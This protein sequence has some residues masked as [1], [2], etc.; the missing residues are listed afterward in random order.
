[1]E[2]RFGRCIVGNADQKPI[3]GMAV[4][5]DAEVWSTVGSE[6]A[7]VPKENSMSKQE[8]SP[9]GVFMRVLVLVGLVAAVVLAFQMGKEI[10]TASDGMMPRNTANAAAASPGLH[11]AAAG[12]NAEAVR[13]AIAGGADP[14]AA[15]N[16][17]DSSRDGMTP[18]M[19]ACFE[20]GPDVVKALVDGGARTEVRTSDGRTALIYAAGWGNV[21]KVQTL[22]DAGATVD[23]RA[24]DGMTALMFAAARGDVEC[25]RALVAAGARV[26]E[27]NKWRQ[28]ALMGAARTGS[29]EKVEALLGAG[30][31]VDMHDQ[32]GDSALSIAAA[33]SDADARIVE[34]LLSGGAKVDE[35]DTDGVT[36]LMKAAESGD[37]AKVRALLKAGASAQ[38]KDRTNGWSARDWAAKRDDERGR[39]VVAILEG[40]GKE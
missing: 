28:T 6:P 33:S 10:P 3:P 20:G 4:A 12:G 36:A 16:E 18:L 26:D 25:V 17:Q 38:V 39:A 30:A 13:A 2:G 19:V 15:L 1:M 21:Q 27:R 14:N 7:D 23:A 40:G 24:S 34:M 29:L 32:Y 9:L 8:M 37:E 11:Q 22:L 5:A 31:S 35:G